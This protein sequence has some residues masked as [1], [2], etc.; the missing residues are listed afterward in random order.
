MY[1]TRLLMTCILVVVFGLSACGQ[2]G[3]GASGNQSQQAGQQFLNERGGTAGP[4]AGNAGGPT[5]GQSVLGTVDQVEGNKIVVKE[6]MGN[7][8]MT[9]QL[10]ADTK[11][12]KQVPGQVSDIKVGDKFT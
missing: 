12:Q 8:S 7:T 4:A 2:V 1:R 9:I 10:A 3:G 6:P 11:V 5:E